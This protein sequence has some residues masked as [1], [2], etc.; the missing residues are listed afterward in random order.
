MATV[1][2]V[3]DEVATV[4]G[5]KALL[6]AEGIEVLS[7]DNQAQAEAILASCPVDA[8]LTDVRLTGTRDTSGLDLL[9]FIKSRDLATR[10]IVMTGYGAPGV[11]QSA[12]EL[13]AVF[14]FE[15]PV[16]LEVLA[17]ALSD[18]GVPCHLVER[19]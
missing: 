1:L 17:S 18:I 14:Y 15:K 13:G 5:L 16:D 9:R 12:Y 2:I 4:F 10:S 8:L 11:L 3:D 7:T 19:R 6:E